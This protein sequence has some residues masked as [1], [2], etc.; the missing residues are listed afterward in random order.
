MKR[1]ATIR[2]DRRPDSFSPFPMSFLLV[3]HYVPSFPRGLYPRPTNLVYFPSF[4]P[5]MYS[6]LWS[7]T[8]RMWAQS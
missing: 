4:I 2:E 3:V 5:G 6:T 7:F 8:L 1:R